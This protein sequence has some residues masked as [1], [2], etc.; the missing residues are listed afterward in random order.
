M[1]IY[2]DKRHEG[3][4]LGI[5]VLPYCDDDE[6]CEGLIIKEIVK[7]GRI[8]RDGRFSV[9]DRLIEVNDQTLLNVNFE[10]A[11][12]LI[13]NALKD[14]QLKLN[15]V[16][17]SRKKQINYAL[18]NEASS[19]TPFNKQ[20]QQNIPN[21]HFLPTTTNER[22]INQNDVNLIKN[23]IKDKINED[24]F[25][26]LNNNRNKLNQFTST[27]SNSS[28][29]TTTTTATTTTSSGYFNEVSPD[30]YATESNFKRNGTFNASNTRRIGKKYHIRLIKDLNGLGFSITTRDNQVGQCPIYIK[31]ILPVGAAKKDGNLKSGDRL[32]EV[33]GI[34]M[35]GKSHDEALKVLREIETGR[36]VD[37]I[38]SRQD[39]TTSTSE[40]ERTPSFNASIDKKQQQ[41]DEGETASNA[42]LPRQLPSSS[43][44]IE[45][46]S[47]ATNHQLDL[48]KTR[49]VLSYNI[50]LN[51]TGSAG[52][53]VSV[54]GKTSTSNTTKK[55]T[56][57][58]I[59]VKS[60]FHGGAAFK[61]GRLKPN[62]QLI[63]INGISLLNSNNEQAME[64]LRR[65]LINNEGVHTSSNSINLV[66][67]RVTDPLESNP[68]NSLLS[69]AFIKDE[70]Y[71]TFGVKPTI[72]IYHQRN[73]STISS[74]SVK[75]NFYEQNYQPS[76][77]QTDNHFMMVNCMNN[78][79]NNQ[80]QFNNQRIKSTTNQYQQDGDFN[81]LYNLNRKSNLFKN[82][83]ILKGSS[84]ST[85][86]NDAFTI[87]TPVNTSMKNDFTDNE[88]ELTIQ[89][90]MNNSNRTDVL[91]EN[92]DQENND[93]NIV[94]HRRNYFEQQQQQQLHQQQN[95]IAEQLDSSLNKSK[96]SQ[97]MNLR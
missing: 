72:D 86:S 17:N 75:L 24:K 20:Q 45:N 62:D 49:E 46:S 51:D 82:G 52:L 57:L 21:F 54:K 23:T 95:N 61:D 3:G 83:L 68:N 65:V 36:I 64:T 8:D 35:T 26:E 2:L 77:D 69:N 14:N 47:T 73:Q 30:D 71:D 88:N 63:S 55:T 58:G 33:N 28:S 5:H 94:Y 13:S 1:L 67:A 39:A 74:D 78:E 97:M 18:S 96:D 91:I 27:S 37:L 76:S 16:K 93:P 59:F 31:T 41:E 70:L 40:F 25:N 4:P 12:S 34:E 32:L 22:L 87:S 89:K 7:G 50:P 43:D 29:T 15:I 80:Q 42:K 48:T 92:D 53:G 9:G 85:D 6:Q 19:H 84:Q 79:L 66:V 44:K 56:D 60:V 10:T 90:F 38:V 81:E 11:Q